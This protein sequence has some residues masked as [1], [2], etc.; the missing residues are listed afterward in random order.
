MTT[1]R[2]LISEPSAT[3]VNF[4]P[5]VTGILKSYWE[6]HGSRADAFTW[7]DPLWIRKQAEED[8]AGLYRDAPD[9]LGLSCYTWNWDLQC[10]VAR[11]ARQRNPKCL[12]VAGGPDP[13]YKDPDFFRKYPEID[14]VVVKDGEI[15]FTAILETYLAGGR[16]FRH[17]PGLYLPSTT[18]GLQLL[19]EGQT[20]HTFTGPAAVPTEFQYSPYLEQ[21]AMY[22]RLMQEQKGLWI[23]ATLETN[24]GCPYTCSYC[25]WGSSTMSKLRRFD[26]SRIDVE[27]DWLGRVGVNFLFLADANFGILERDLAIADHLGETRAKYGFPQRMYYSAAKNNPERVVEVARRT[28]KWQLT[29]EHVLAVQHTDPEVLAGTER[30]NISPAKYREVVAKLHADGIPCETQLILGIPGDTAEKWKS[31]L[32][33][34]MAWGVHEN[35]QIS[36]YSL[37]PNAPAAEPKFKNKWQIRTI[38][39]RLVPYAGSREKNAETDIKSRIVVGWRGYSDADWLESVTYSAFVRAYHNRSLTR[40]PGIYLHFVHGVSYREY[41]DAVIDEFC[42]YSPVVAPLYARVRG[43][44][45]EFL[46]EPEMTDMMELEDFP[47][48]AFTVDPIKWLYAKTCLRLDDFYSALSSFLIKRFPQGTNLKSVIEYQKQLVITPEYDSSRGKSFFLNHDWP[49]FFKTALVLMDY[50]P[51]DEPSAFFVPRHSRI[52]EEDRLGRDSFMDFAGGNLEERRY[53]WLNQ[54]VRLHNTAEVSN[55]RHPVISAAGASLLRIAREF[56]PVK[57]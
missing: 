41:Y 49:S 39:R 21:T 15:P 30:S 11:W 18:P 12:I 32:A 51:L 24:R 3:G 20:A 29:H 40:L 44:Y 38:D 36:F 27:V 1:P 22:E 48:A 16:D 2:I 28:Y 47:D 14:M 46:R 13:D 23:H 55:L 45:E 4:L 25:D 56:A 37:L 9:I 43:L 10:E 5:Y 17:I 54:S 26:M 8:L 19:H 35:F 7:L 57:L 52:A 33:E 6:H 42:R 31:C 53:R 50:Q 34:L